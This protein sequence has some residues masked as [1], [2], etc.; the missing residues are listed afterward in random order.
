MKLFVAITRG[1]FPVGPQNDV[2]HEL[3]GQ[4]LEVDQFAPENWQSPKRKVEK[5]SSSNHHFFS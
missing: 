1:V 2:C 4:N 5:G 3:E